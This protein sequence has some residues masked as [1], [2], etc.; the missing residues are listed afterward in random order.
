M[1]ENKNDKSICHS[2]TKQKKKVHICLS[3][4]IPAEQFKNEKK[5]L[6]TIYF[7]HTHTHTLVKIQIQSVQHLMQPETQ[8]S[9]APTNF[10]FLEVPAAAN[11]RNIYI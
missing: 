3:E 10:Q 7:P 9:P 4:N 5:N 8:A 6:Y 2:K 1:Q 11:A